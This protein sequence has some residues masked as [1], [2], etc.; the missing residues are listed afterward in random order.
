MSVTIEIIERIVLSGGQFMSSLSIKGT[1]RGLV[2]SIEGSPL[3]ENIK[4]EL[5]AKLE[6][7]KGF[8][9]GASFCLIGGNL[10]A[11][12]RQDLINLCLDNEMIL[13]ES[14]STAG[15]IQRE[16]TAT[17]IH[18]EAENNMVINRNIRSGQRITAKND[19]VVVGNVNP[20]AELIAG[21]NIVVMGSLRGV[22]HAGAEGDLYA[23]ITAQEMLPSQIRIG[24]LVACSPERNDS[25]SLSQTE[26]AYVKDNKIVVEKFNSSK[27]CRGASISA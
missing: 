17:N 21:G 12:Q 26:I 18:R 8:F 23:T 13:D 25:A 19:L 15:L 27:T 5:L 2:I 6:A 14:I 4:S 20:G 16:K 24:G 1:M 22:A 11:E 9:K 3:F 10:E 7:R